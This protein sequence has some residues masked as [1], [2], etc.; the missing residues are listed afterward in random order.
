MTPLF[1]RWTTRPWLLVVTLVLIVHCL[2]GYD[3]A[4]ALGRRGDATGQ[5]AQIGAQPGGAQLPAPVAEVR[6]AILSAVRSGRI[7]DLAAPIEWN[8]LKPTIADTPVDDPIAYWKK[9][10]GDGE[11]REILAILGEILEAGH[12]ALPLGKDIEN[13]KMYIWPAFAEMPLDKLTPDQEVRLYRLVKP[14][15]VKAMRQKKKW[16]WYRLAIRADGTWHSFQK[17]D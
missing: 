7:E 9:I 4:A 6:D 16:T 15:E 14:D 10:S 3:R 12:V 17:S 13:N 8:E 1:P 5:P 2:P 11:G